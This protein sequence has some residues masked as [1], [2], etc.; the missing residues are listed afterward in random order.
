MKRPLVLVVS[1]HPLVFDSIRAGFEPDF[2]VMTMR[3]HAESV[4]VAAGVLEPLAVI[5]DLSRRS[6][7]S[8]AMTKRVLEEIPDLPLVLLLDRETHPDIKRREWIERGLEFDS[9]GPE[10]A[11]GLHR[12][13]GGRV[14]AVHVDGNVAPGEAFLET[15]PEAAYSPTFSC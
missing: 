8:A 13:F 10:L 5:V 15:I 7:S 14:R 4:I 3:P 9:L 11:L 1:D 2:E 12:A 6:V